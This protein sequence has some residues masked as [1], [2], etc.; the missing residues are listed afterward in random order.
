MNWK[1]ALDGAWQGR[2]N[3]S[4]Y[5]IGECS[6]AE[7]DTILTTIGAT[8]IALAQL[9]FDYGHDTGGLL[10]PQDWIGF[11]VWPEDAQS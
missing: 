8:T 4:L 11:T 7:L 6:D 1:N 5:G 9:N 10:K 2:K 3:I